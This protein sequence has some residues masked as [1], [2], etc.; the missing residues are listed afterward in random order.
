MEKVIKMSSER[1]TVGDRGGPCWLDEEF[2]F[3]SKSNG[4]PLEDFNQGS[5]L[6]WFMFLT[7]LSVHSVENRL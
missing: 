2:G 4:E 6:S 3:H 7:D 1:K 5:D